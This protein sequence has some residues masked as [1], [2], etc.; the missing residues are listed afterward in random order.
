MYIPLTGTQSHSGG[1]V[2]LAIFSLHLSGISSI[3]GAINVVATIINIR[4]AGMTIH[5]LPLFVW[6]ILMQAIII[7]LCIPVLAGAITM[8]IT[9][10]NINTTFYDPAGGGDPVL[11]QHLFYYYENL[12]NNFSNYNS[13]EQYSLS[14]QSIS[15]WSFQSISS[16]IKGKI[17][18]TAITGNNFDFSAF[19]NSFKILGI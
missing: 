18:F 12:Y 14:F 13:S 11:Y 5:R 9:D 6:A 4:A 1:S 19:R 7:L 15:S 17:D 10:R 3:L 16:W 2:D 8:I